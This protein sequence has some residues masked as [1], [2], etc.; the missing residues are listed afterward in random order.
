MSFYPR[1][2]FGKSDMT[3]GNLKKNI[4]FNLRKYI[5]SPFLKNFKD[6]DEI[7]LEIEKKINDK[8]YDLDDNKLYELIEKEYKNAF[9]N[10]QLEE[11]KENKILKE[12]NKEEK[13]IENFRKDMPFRIFLIYERDFNNEIGKIPFVDEE[14]LTKLSSKFKNNIKLNSFN[15][16]FEH[17]DIDLTDYSI[18]V[19]FNE[20]S[21]FINKKTFDLNFFEKY[22]MEFTIKKVDPKNEDEEGDNGKMT[23][24]KCIENFCKEKQLKRSHQLICYSCKKSVLFKEKKELYYLP[25]ILIICFNRIVRETNK[26]YKNEEFIDYPINDMDMK[27]FIIGPDK[28]H[29]KYD[30]FAVIQHYGSS[31]YGHYIAVCKNNGQWFLYDD[32]SCSETNANSALSSHAYVLFYRRQ[33]D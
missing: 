17:L 33:T 12:K 21:K 4:Y 23:L 26:V 20:E 10:Y 28:E 24:R 19:E 31:G 5:L 32:S 1:M 3:V 15:D 25:K 14:N 29:S 9:K 7:S 13:C 11:K 18:I 30:L 27:E 2:I 8:N 22:E 6:K 16:T